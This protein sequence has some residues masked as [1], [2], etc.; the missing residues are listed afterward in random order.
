MALERGEWTTYGDVVI[1]VMGSPRG[2][3]GVG[4]AAATDPDFPSPHRVLMNDGSINPG[5]ATS[6]GL[7]PEECR[8]RLEE[9]GVQFTTDDV[10]DRVHYVGWADLLARDAGSALE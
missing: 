5:W 9:E 10:A 3:R 2:A 4:R 1:A 6:D 7:G 8:R